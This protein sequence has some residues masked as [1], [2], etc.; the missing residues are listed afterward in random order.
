MASFDNGLTATVGTTEQT[1][2]TAPSGTHLLIGVI[3]TNTYG[4]T[5]GL[6]VKLVRSSNTYF[7]SHDRRIDANQTVDLLMGTKISLT[8][9]DEIKVKAN[10]DNAFTVIATVTEDVLV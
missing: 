6:T 8:T 5:L 9:G 4:S 3:G 2:Y 7:I 10:A 1:I